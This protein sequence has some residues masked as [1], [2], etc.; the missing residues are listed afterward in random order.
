MRSRK[1][2][3]IGDSL[4][5]LKELPEEIQDEIGYALQKVQEGLT[6]K[7]AKLLKGFS[8]AVMEDCV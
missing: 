7:S 1:A 8:P 5:R 3:W 6:P 2:I 4:K